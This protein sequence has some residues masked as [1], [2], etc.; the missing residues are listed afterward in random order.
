MAWFERQSGFKIKALRTDEGGE[1]EGEMD[2]LLTEIGIEHEPTVG[3]SSQS[4]GMAECSNRTLLDMVCPM[5]FSSGLPLPLW[6]EAIVTACYVKNR[7]ATRAIPSGK[8]PYE[9][10]TG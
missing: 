3:Y 6:G 9:M 10:F 4:N 1:F 7:M 5:L 8:T 2:L